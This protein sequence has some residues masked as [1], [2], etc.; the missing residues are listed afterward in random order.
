MK[1]DTFTTSPSGQTRARGRAG[2]HIVYARWTARCFPFLFN[3]LCVYVCFSAHARAGL[4][5]P[6]FSCSGTLGAPALYVLVSGFIYLGR[7]SESLSC[8]WTQHEIDFRI[9]YDPQ[10]AT[11]QQL[12]GGARTK[13]ILGERF[14]C[15]REHAQS[16]DRAPKKPET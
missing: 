15:A 7:L 4:L 9:C 16:T 3:I 10:S 14:R 11:D 12:P 13:S 6:F 8:R 2:G 5:G 1:S